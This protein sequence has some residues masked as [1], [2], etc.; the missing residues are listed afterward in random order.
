L[1]GFSWCFC[2]GDWVFYELLCFLHV[3]MYS[4]SVRMIYSMSVCILEYIE[5]LAEYA[6]NKLWVGQ[7]GKCM[8]PND[9]K[10]RLIP[11]LKYNDTK[12]INH[13]PHHKDIQMSH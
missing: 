7:G 10:L 4:F 6:A 8:E 3:S 13:S 9:N 1:L 12:I 5:T 11:L 2:R